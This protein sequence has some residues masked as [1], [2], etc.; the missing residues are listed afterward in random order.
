MAKDYIFVYGTLRRGSRSEMFRLLANNGEFVD[1]ATCKG[2]LYLVASTYPGMVE[3]EDPCDIVHGE[4]YQLK[5]PDKLL[6]TFDD[7]EE[8]GP[9]FRQPTEYIRRKMQVT[10]KSGKEVAAWVYIFNRKTEGLELIE[11]GDFLQYHANA[12]SND[13]NS[14]SDKLRNLHK[15]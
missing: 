13:G 8:C 12:L 4:V 3:S 1:D 14:R 7:Y 5:S 9:N 6:S 11:S 10:L 2:K 15:S